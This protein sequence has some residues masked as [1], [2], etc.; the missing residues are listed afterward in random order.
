M[1]KRRLRLS[2]F[3]TCIIASL[4]VFSLSS[5]S[6]SISSQGPTA[7]VI[8]MKGGIG[9][10]VQDFVHRGIATA[11][12]HNAKVIILRI[13][14]PG[15]LS[16][17]MRGI[18]QDILSSPIPV[19]S[20]VAP[21]G[22][23]AASAGTYI[24]YASH[25][26]AMAPGTNLGAATPVNIGTP[27]QPDAKEKSKPVK[28]DASKRKA[29]NDARAYIRSLAQ[30]RGRNV[31]WAELAVT[32]AESLSAEEALKLNVITLMAKN[33]PD[34]L[35][36]VDG[37]KITLKGNVVTMQTK[38]LT[39][40]VMHH[41]WRYKF[42]KAITDPSVAYILLMIGFYGLFFEFMHPGFAVPGVIGAICLLIGL[43]ALQMLPV[44]YAG[45]ALIILGLAFIVTEAFLPS[46]GILGIGGIISFII[47]SIMLM[48]AE[49]FGYGIPVPVIITVVLFT[50]VFVGGIMYLALSSRKRPVVSGTSLLL[51]KIG[52]VKKDN[53]GQWVRVEGERWQCKSD[54]TIQSGDS[55]QVKAVDG[56]TLLVEKVEEKI[57]GENK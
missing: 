25:I 21:S 46:F 26:A 12:R 28:E 18:I 32:K 6:A 52:V 13:D 39:I 30:M 49:M 27:S 16:T 44:N 55:V 37:T 43:Y 5:R 11:S 10:A 3:L 29:L 51:G 35:Q 47:G 45:L 33:I 19:I 48:K 17:S 38:G 9:P 1:L 53:Q 22:A 8:N 4:L 57:K 2:I 54:G 36:K 14:T 20:F 34:L 23:R 56:L 7:L 50:V 42:L 24:L 31:K 15:G 40:K 41:G